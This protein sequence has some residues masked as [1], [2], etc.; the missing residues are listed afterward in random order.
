[1]YSFLKLS[2][3]KLIH[4]SLARECGSSFEREATNFSISCS[5]TLSEQV[6]KTNSIFFRRE[7]A[8]TLIP[9]KFL[10]IGAAAVVPVLE[11]D[12]V[13]VIFSLCATILRTLRK[14]SLYLNYVFQP[15]SR[16]TAVSGLIQFLFSDFNER[17][18]AG[19]HNPPV[20]TVHTEFGNV[21]AITAARKVDIKFVNDWFIQL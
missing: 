21:Y 12:D 15:R 1:M 16:T 8:R 17:G 9:F 6:D 3:H 19:S 11:L 7:K 4:F 18:I 20:L 2:A 5:T 10:S 14:P 13:E